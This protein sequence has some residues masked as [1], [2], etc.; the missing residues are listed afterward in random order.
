M[1]KQT[2]VGRLSSL[3]DASAAVVGEV[4][5]ERVLNR[6]VTEARSAT[7]AT[8]AALGVM[9]P[10]GVLSDFIHDGISD[11]TARGIG[12]PPLGRGVLGTV[13]RERKTLRLDDL[14]A[15]PDSFGFPEGHPEMESFLGVPVTVGD[16]V[17][18]NLYLTEKKGGFDDADVRLVEALALIAGSAINNA[19]LHERL[20]ALAI[21]EDRD[22]IARD[23]HDSVIQDLFAVGL[24]LQALAEKAPDETISP[25]L[26]DAVDQL[27]TSV[28]TLRAYI[29]ELRA[30]A[31]IR[32]PLSRQLENLVGRMGNAYPTEVDLHIKGDIDSIESKDAEEL[33]KLVSE[34]LS[35]AL[36]HSAAERVEVLARYGKKG[37]AL[38]ISDDGLG[39]DPNQVDRGM[40]LLNMSERVRRLGGELDIKS[41]TNG[42]TRLAIR[43]R[44]L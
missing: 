7:G 5:L 23:L 30:T 13:V 38:K 29:Y 19:R 18:G 17:F 41:D 26:N 39:F 34:A 35:N 20:Q 3:I 6:L 2:K 31:S 32:E 44:D 15:H 33:L 16:E 10:H 28:E 25:F 12:A 11:K 27:H 4:D 42:G 37:L 43:F 14:G 1:T 21:I 40:G 24:N 9:G 8:Y 22:R 36:R